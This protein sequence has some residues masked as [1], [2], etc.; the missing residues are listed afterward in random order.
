VKTSTIKLPRLVESDPRSPEISEIITTNLKKLWQK[1][2]TK[3]VFLPF[4]EK[5]I[6]VLQMEHKRGR[7]V[8]GFE[9]IER[10]LE[11][12]AH[13]LNL[14]DEKSSSQRGARVSRLLIISNDGTERFLRKVENLLL[15]HEDR[16]LGLIIDIDSEKLGKMFFGEGK[17]AK[18]MMLEHKESVANALFSLCSA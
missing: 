18:I 17:T 13:G 15:D 8:R 12:Q 2:R 1:A 6:K 11:M 3:A 14:A 5:L 10:K 16:V 4:S 7:I 9:G